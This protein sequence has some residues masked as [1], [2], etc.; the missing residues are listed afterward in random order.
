MNQMAKYFD[1]KIKLRAFSQ[2]NLVLKKAEVNKG[3]T[4]M[5]ELKPK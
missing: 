3:N 5:L 2:R 1:K 4:R